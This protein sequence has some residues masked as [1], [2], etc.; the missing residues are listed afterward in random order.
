MLKRE[1]NIA[2]KEL[3][4]QIQEKDN[5]IRTLMF[6][7]EEDQMKI[8]ELE[9][10]KQYL[11]Q[12]L[13]LVQR[14]KET[15]TELL[16]TQL[17]RQENSYLQ[18]IN[19]LDSEKQNAK[20]MLSHLQNVIKS[21]DYQND[22]VVKKLNFSA[23]LSR[24]ESN[25]NMGKNP[26]MTTP[27]SPVRINLEESKS[28]SK[29]NSGM[30]N[31]H[32]SS[33]VKSRSRNPSASGLKFGAN[34]IPVNAEHSNIILSTQ[35]S[36]N[37]GSLKRLGLSRNPSVTVTKTMNKPNEHKY[38]NGSLFL[39]DN[40]EGHQYENIQTLDSSMNHLNVQNPY[41]RSSKSKSKGGNTSDGGK[42]INHM[43]D[44]HTLSK[45]NSDDVN[46]TLM[47]SIVNLFPNKFRH[48]KG[49]NSGPCHPNNP[50]SSFSSS[51]NGSLSK[52]ELQ[53]KLRKIQ[54]SREGSGEL[55][56]EV[57]DQEQDSEFLSDSPERKVKEDFA[58]QSNNVRSSGKVVMDKQTYLKMFEAGN[59][60]KNINGDVLC[61]KCNREFTIDQ[62][63]S[64]ANHW[65]MCLKKPAPLE[66]FCYRINEEDNCEVTVTESEDD[67]Y[68]NENY[69]HHYEDYLIHEKNNQE[70]E[71]QHQKKTQRYNNA[72]K[73][74]NTVYLQPE[75]D[76]SSDES[77]DDEDGEYDDDIEEGV[78]CNPAY[79]Q[80]F[81]AQH[82]RNNRYA[83]PQ[84]ILETVETESVKD[85][86]ET[87]SPVFTLNKN[88]MSQNV[89]NSPLNKP[90]SRYSQSP[91]SRHSKRSK[92]LP[93]VHDSTEQS[94][95]LFNDITHKVHPD[96]PKEGRPLKDN[97]N[98]VPVHNDRSKMPLKESAKKK[99]TRRGRRMQQE[100][101]KVVFCENLNELEDEAENEPVGYARIDLLNEQ[102]QESED[103]SIPYDHLNSKLNRIENAVHFF[104]EK[105]HN[106]YSNCINEVGTLKD[107]IELKSEQKS[108]SRMNSVH[109][110]GSALKTPVQ[111]NKYCE[112]NMSS[113]KNTPLINDGNVIIGHNS[114]TIKSKMRPRN[115]GNYSKD[116]TPEGRSQHFSRNLKCPEFDKNDD[117]DGIKDITRIINN[118]K[119][120][121][122]DRISRN[123]SGYRHIGASL[124]QYNMLTQSAAA[125]NHHPSR[126]F[127][128][129]L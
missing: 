94:V 57:E 25:F 56:K 33:N 19:I 6:E 77:Y 49:S 66:K 17:K 24:S 72:V 26:N 126:S 11:E 30:K 45:E 74:Q 23:C 107:Y 102:A 50:V 65:R 60:M 54:K 75:G 128:I 114:S 92:K 63:I 3:R 5:Y 106:N 10:D 64:D 32:L 53:E 61:K 93:P 27:C 46:G 109:N 78:P 127:A 36:G 8:S 41:K 70:Y 115:Y 1:H 12:Q 90:N 47:N 43:S 14:E 42:G 88:N 51:Q 121:S 108:K 80:E 58:Q 55:I 82:Q 103:D 79:D 13:D 117:C 119:N 118:K 111:R 97:Y 91:T 15:N 28:T 67:E 7:K 21:G 52:E 18:Q 104:Y 2:V 59:L 116:V 76:G 20:N 123:N 99:Q 69:G 83:C 68:F 120:R 35:R 98:S 48:K 112:F 124:S 37:F 4:R 39:L 16:E 110:F 122:Q 101:N 34:S 40:G 29:Y 84:V 62:L 9:N 125:I 113:A 22:S 38:K 44:I 85:K 73:H 81:Y 31:N 71:S 87:Q 86:E 100:Q 95:R 96:N 105:M 129:H 89:M